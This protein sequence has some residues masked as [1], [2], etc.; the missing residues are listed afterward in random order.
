MIGPINNDHTYAGN[1][2]QGGGG[3][4]TLIGGY[5]NDTFHYDS[6]D[7]GGVK[8]DSIADFIP[9]SD[10]LTFSDVGFDNLF[11]AQNDR[12]VENKNYVRLE[13]STSNLAQSL[14]D[15]TLDG[16]A[17]AK[18]IANSTSYLAL[19]DV[20]DIK[21]GS[22]AGVF[23]Y[24]DSDVTVA[25]MTV[26][27]ELNSV[28]PDEM[29]VGTLDVG[30]EDIWAVD[31]VTSYQGS[32][33]N[34]EY[35]FENWSTDE[36]GGHTVTITDQGGGQD[37]LFMSNAANMV[38]L[39]TASPDNS[40]EYLR[41]QVDADVVSDL[42]TGQGMNLD[43]TAFAFTTPDG[44]LDLSRDV[45]NVVMSND[46]YSVA[47]VATGLSW[48]IGQ[49]VLPII[50][51]DVTGHFVGGTYNDDIIN[52]S[53]MADT[54][55]G[56]MI[57]FGGWGNDT[58]QGAISI[59]NDIYG[60]AGQD[61][62]TGGNDGSDLYGG[63]GNDT[64][65]GGAGYDWLVGGAGA[66]TL[67]GGDAYDTYVFNA[68]SDAG[69]VLSAADTITDFFN[70]YNGNSNGEAIYLSDAGFGDLF[71]NFGKTKLVNGDN[72]LEISASGDS[73][74]T[75]LS[76]GSIESQVQAGGIADNTDY[77][78]VLD[79]TDNSGG[80]DSGFYLLYDDDSQYA[81]GV[82]LLAKL[83][84]SDGTS[85]TL[86]TIGPTNFAATE[87]ERIWADDKDSQ[88][89]GNHYDTFYMADMYDSDTNAAPEWIAGYDTIRDA[90]GH[91]QL[92]F[93]D[94]FDARL[95]VMSHPTDSNMVRVLVQTVPADETI[96]GFLTSTT[97]SDFNNTMDVSRDVE[98]LKAYHEG[99]PAQD[100]GN[101]YSLFLADTKMG[102][103][104]GDQLGIVIGG[105]NEANVMD[106]TT[107]TSID[108]SLDSNTVA[109][110]LMG[111]A[112]ADTLIGTL[113]GNNTL[114]GGGGA[115]ILIGGN[116]Q[117]IIQG[118]GGPDTLTGG[119]GADR[120]KITNYVQSGDKFGSTHDTITD[121]NPAEGD[122]IAI[123]D[124]AFSGMYSNNGYTYADGVNYTEI[125]WSGASLAD[126]NS[127]LSAGAIEGLVSPLTGSGAYA[128]YFQFTDSEGG[129]DSANY[130]LYDSDSSASG[131]MRVLAQLPNT[132]T[133]ASMDGDALTSTGKEVFWDSSGNDIL[134]GKS[135]ATR[136][137]FEH[138]TA[139][140]LG[141]DDVIYDTGDQRDVISFE[142]LNDLSLRIQEHPSNA[143]HLLAEV[144]LGL[145][146]EN[147]YDINAAHMTFHSPENSIDFSR[148]IAEVS[149]S[150]MVENVTDDLYAVLDESF[151]DELSGAEAFYVAAGAES[152]DTLDLSA[153]VDAKKM[154][155]F[156]QG[157][158][159]VL[160]GA[161]STDA[162]IGNSG[163]DTLYGNAGDDLLMGDG[164]ADIL[165]G[166]AGADTFFYYEPND[167]G[168]SLA[169]ADAIRDF[170]PGVDRFHINNDEFGNLLAQN[171]G[172]LAG[173]INYAEVSFSGTDSTVL[174]GAL[175]SGSIESLISATGIADGS[176]YL[177][178]LSFTDNDG[179]EDSAS[180][181]LYDNDHTDSAG[182]TLLASLNVDDST[183]VTEDK[184]SEADFSFSLSF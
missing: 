107:F 30:R 163:R 128:A 143:D 142:N 25:G 141:G 9:G 135:K 71:T 118:A 66:D 102:D 119:G 117:D 50:T 28:D 46:W 122:L 69:T 85:I 140:P 91:D 56:G 148:H 88:E 87:N 4:D 77:I 127:A 1:F 24:Y 131:S 93:E 79:F 108:A 65:V 53:G 40:A 126:L 27:A 172:V 6:P 26:L 42:S 156:G 149:V 159:D 89:R 18:G 37:R 98:H 129:E 60:G 169:L 133:A 166:G 61:Q 151:I 154:V 147:N 178:F 115:D 110:M 45:E 57:V 136:Y 101:A 139:D 155:L 176:P 78:A 152:N 51:G 179:G 7:D 44:S 167:G 19:V 165:S 13:L 116:Y 10:L 35:I 184:I 54:A 72:Y 43:H 14:S 114:H 132:L 41:F 64:L 180:Y 138:T 86:D 109:L 38:G 70:V 162:L 137:I 49:S 170:T 94:F 90:G 47:G 33:E 181:L 96:A 130:L 31:G 82:T 145:V 177:A 76:S 5:A 75:I 16:L 182:V 95:K 171:N 124:S 112:G 8:G 34:T 123:K 158:D 17:K 63:D 125:S 157:G 58:I 62:L 80:E 23:L 173:G 183:P 20:T 52:V 106:A 3:D 97:L 175:A 174:D 83:E 153:M 120:F 59:S 74:D 103:L 113:S 81:T 164:G 111:H 36:L 68:P 84:S 150:E 161:D 146:S 12:F 105:D 99:V 32:T 168:A 48:E 2:I 104:S 22:G 160:T 11:S 67:T 21:D 29:D 92:V 55:K 134:A 100:E 39:L 73:L 121:F 15:G 144:D